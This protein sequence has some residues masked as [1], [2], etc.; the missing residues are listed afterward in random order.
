MLFVLHLLL[1]LP[2]DGYY[3]FSDLVNDSILNTL[4]KV[5]YI[6]ITCI[7]SGEK[8]INGDIRFL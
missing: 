2:V 3:N 8:Y 1:L 5:I 7:F 4:M 6:P